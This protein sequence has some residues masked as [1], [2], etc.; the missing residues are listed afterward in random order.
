LN[1]GLSADDWVRMI[2][3]I[4]ALTVVIG[5]AITRGARIPRAAWPSLLFMALIWAAIIASAAL[6]FRHFRPGGL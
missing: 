2:A 3:I 6:A 4:M 1:S 5:T